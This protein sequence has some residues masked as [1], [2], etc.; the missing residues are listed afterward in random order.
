MHFIA[1]CLSWLFVAGLAG[2][3]LVILLTFVD[4]FREI[5]SPDKHPESETA[6]SPDSTRAPAA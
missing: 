6:L 4:D 1:I 3:A 2:S 5:F